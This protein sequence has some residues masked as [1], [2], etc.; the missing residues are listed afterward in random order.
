M[1]T[2]KRK[3]KIK[4]FKLL[5]II[6]VLIVLLTYFF[7]HVYYKKVNPKIIEVAE[8]KLKKFT[9]SFLSNNIGYDILN[10]KNLEN[11]LV[12]NKNKNGE[13]LYV[14]YNLDK[15]YEALQV[16][17]NVIEDNIRDLEVGKFE[18]IRD[19]NIISNNNG[20]I[21]EVPL[22]I[23]SDNAL[24]SSF[25]PKIYMKVN[26]VGT[27]L[28]NIK[29][30]ITDYGFNNAL[31]ELYVT[32]KITEELITPVTKNEIMIDYDV[33]VASKVING[34]VPE[35]YGGIINEESS[36]LDIPIT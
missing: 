18:N 25:G 7:L 19:E 10:N 5:I 24:L 21:L 28:T 23:A 14:D 4:L 13:I 27:I 15:A 30:K 9:S 16:V 17:T 29:S 1:K 22:F 35:F 3:R 2:F 8:I 11:I 26:F 6:V 31:V 20:L 32:I 12:I 33:L 36:I 34:R